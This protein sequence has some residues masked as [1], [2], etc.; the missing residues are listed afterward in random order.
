[1]ELLILIFIETVV[2]K[3]NIIIFSI[4]TFTKQTQTPKTVS[5]FLDIFL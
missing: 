4:K 5:Y 2:L 3:S 1:M